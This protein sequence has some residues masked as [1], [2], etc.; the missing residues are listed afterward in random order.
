MA[1]RS[2]IKVLNRVDLPFW[3]AADLEPD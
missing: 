3:Q 1:S 2:G